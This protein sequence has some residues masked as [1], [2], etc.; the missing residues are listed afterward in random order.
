MKTM[1]CYSFGWSRG[2]PFHTF[3]FAS[4]HAYLINNHPFNIRWFFE[5]SPVIRFMSGSSFVA[6][7]VH[8]ISTDAN[9]T[10]T[11]QGMK[12][13]LT[14][15]MLAHSC[16]TSNERLCPMTSV[17]QFWGAEKTF[18]RTEPISRNKERIRWIGNVQETHEAGIDRNGNFVL[19]QTFMLSLLCK[20]AA[21]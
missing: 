18:R 7:Q 16:R 21:L 20:V 6:T 14:K 9:L 10:R 8:R 11:E 17:S 5:T 3:L 19:R 13:F 15:R 4:F 1:C 12:E 2:P